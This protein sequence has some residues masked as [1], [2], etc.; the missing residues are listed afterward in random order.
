VKGRRKRSKKKYNAEVKNQTATDWSHDSREK[1]I[2][3]IRGLIEPLC[4]A[5]GI[6]LVHIEYRGEASGRIL[7]IYIDTAEGVTIDDCVRINRQVGDILDI[8][9]ENTGSYNL[10]VSSPGPNR[11][12]SNQ[13]DYERFIGRQ[14]KI[15]TTQP[16]DGQKNFKGVL[17]GISAESVKLS[18]EGT[19]LS[20]PFKE[21]ARAQL[22]G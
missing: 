17:A 2:S 8:Y 15:S 1:I 6:E 21:I 20:I 13:N 7:R 10:E 9:L 5:E 12:L 4:E 16:I 14:A 3:Q 11:P 22:V 19:I 18:V